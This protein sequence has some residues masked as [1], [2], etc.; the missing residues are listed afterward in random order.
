MKEMQLCGPVDKLMAG[1]LLNGGTVALIDAVRIGYLQQTE[2]KYVQPDSNRHKLHESKRMLVADK[3]SQR[4][5]LTVIN[6]SNSGPELAFMKVR[7]R[8]SG[9][10][11]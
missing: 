9:T 5:A 7:K 3:C 11:P 6:A 8:I 2:L 4:K 1:K 10:L